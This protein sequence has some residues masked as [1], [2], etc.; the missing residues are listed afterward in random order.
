MSEIFDNMME[1][2]DVMISPLYTIAN[3]KPVDDPTLPDKHTPT[4]K[5]I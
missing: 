5:A 4:I 1:R 2:M 3:Q